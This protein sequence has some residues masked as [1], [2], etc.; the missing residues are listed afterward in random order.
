MSA[1]LQLIL[2]ALFFS[3]ILDRYII[4]RWRIYRALWQEQ[5]EAGN[6]INRMQLFKKAIFAGPRRNWHQFIQRAQSNLRLRTNFLPLLELGILALWAIVVCWNY[7]DGNPHIVPAGNEL[8]SAIQSNHLWTQ[9][10]KCGWCAVWNGS[11]HGG[12][13]AFA[14]SINECLSRT[15]D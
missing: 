6:T 3:I 8:G 15:R 1:A 2:L 10:M 11:E 4:S 9:F 13:P 5:K 14:G 7:M 12:F